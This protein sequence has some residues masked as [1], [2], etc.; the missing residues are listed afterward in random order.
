MNTI[1]SSSWSPSYFIFVF[2]K[3]SP[4]RN[5]TQKNDQPKLL[6]SSTHFF[7]NNF[8]SENHKMGFEVKIATIFLHS[9][10]TSKA[11]TQSHNL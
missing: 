1:E 8:F 4:S 5:P 2:I 6:F 11:P 10:F 7:N 9:A 3:P